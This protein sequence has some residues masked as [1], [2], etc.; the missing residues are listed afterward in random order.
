MRILLQKP[1]GDVDAWRGALQRALPDAN[2][3]VWP[4]HAGPADYALVWK[5]PPDLFAIVTPTKAI[6]NIGAGVDALL[7]TPALPDAVPVIRLEDAGM[8]GPMAA[9]VTRAVLHAH[10]GADRYARQQ[11]DAQWSVHRRP[12]SAGFGVGILGLGVLGRAVAAALRP[13]GFAL[14]GWSRQRKEV[15]GVESFAGRAELPAFLARSDVLVCLLPSTPDTRDLLDRD[16]MRLLPPGATLVNVAR[17]DIV[18]DADLVELLDVGHLS[19][20]TLDVFRE[21]PLPPAHP[22]WR[23]PAIVVTPHVSAATMMEDSVAQIAQKIL[24]LEAGTARDGC[25]RSQARLLTCSRTAPVDGRARS[26]TLSGG[27]RRLVHRRDLLAQLEDA[28]L[29]V[30]LRVEPRERPPETPG[31]PSAARSTPSS[32]AAAA[33]AAP[34]P[35]AARA[36]ELGEILVAFEHVAELPRHRRRGRRTAAST[37]PGSPGR[38]ARRRSRRSAG[39]RAS[40]GCCRRGSRRAGAAWRRRR[41]DRSS[42]ATPVERHRRQ[43]ATYGSRRSGGTK[44]CV[45]QEVARA[46]RRTWRCRARA[47]CAKGA[48]RR[49]RGCVPGSG[50]SSV[51]VRGIVE[52]GRA[53]RRGA[54]RRRSGSSASSCSVRAVDRERGHRRDLALDELGHEGVLLHDLRVGPACRAGRT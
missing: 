28:V 54:D 33:C 5:P 7:R 17:G 29:P 14:A 21:E 8:A 38:C 1:G 32:A 26:V 24:R 13:F 51:S 36:V 47:A 42:G 50:R 31:R 16:T 2:V 34:R 44:S 9:Y 45:E 25:R 22:F 37:G 19:G 6:F 48:A 3:S 18:V 20:A 53:S 46:H 35:D 49:R 4:N 39:R 52:L 23:H 15:D 40:T 10:Q 43:I 12:P 30:A 41:R 11:R 27:Q